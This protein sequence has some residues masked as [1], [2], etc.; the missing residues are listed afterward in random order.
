MNKVMS[1]LN[2]HTLVGWGMLGLLT[3]GIVGGLI[4]LNLPA[5]FLIGAILGGLLF[6]IAGS[7]LRVPNRVFVAAQSLLGCMIARVFSV[8]VL[9]NT[10]AHWILVLISVLS[11]LGCSFLVGLFLQKRHILLGSTAIWGSWPGAAS[12]MSIMA[13]AYGADIRLVALM[14]YLRVVMVAVSASVVALS[15]GSSS[16]PASLI[17]FPPIVW[18]QLMA[19]LLMAG[20]CTGVALRT[21]IPAGPML[22]TMGVGA[23]LNNLEWVQIELPPV[24]LLVTYAL[25]GWTIG[26]KFTKSVFMYALGV[27]P[28]LIGVIALLLGMCGCI[29][30]ALV[31]FAGISPLTAYLATSPGGADSIA[32]IA[33]SAPVDMAFVMS[34]QLMRFISVLLIGPV[35]SKIMAS[36]VS[37]ISN[38]MQ[39]PRF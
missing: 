1:F 12:V 37:K 5:A 10:A 38:A 31:A 6:A 32:I 15:V 26:L 35:I 28:K 11:V 4:L 14:Q 23:V 24:L 39:S 8:S 27:L 36:R 16:P 25:I 29:A 3:M 18:H 19:T 7:P 33:A 34:V 21:K 2:Q 9:E 22:L 13:E 30:L 20:I 17:S